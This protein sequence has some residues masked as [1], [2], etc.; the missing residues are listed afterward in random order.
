M[1]TKLD[2]FEDGFAGGDNSSARRAALA[3][4]F[5]LPGDMSA[6]ALLEALN[7]L[8]SYDEYKRA[9]VEMKIN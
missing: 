1:I 9:V 5:E 2:F 8:S 6:K 3:E 7:L 4:R